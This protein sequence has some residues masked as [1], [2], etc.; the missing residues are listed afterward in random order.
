VNQLSKL[1]ELTRALGTE[2]LDPLYI[3]A[4]VSNYGLRAP[5][6]PEHVPLY[7]ALGQSDLTPEGYKEIKSKTTAQLEELVKWKMISVQPELHLSNI[8]E[9][10]LVGM[11]R[12]GSRRALPFTELLLFVFNAIL[13]SKT[14]RTVLTST[15]STLTH[16]LQ[17][18]TAQPIG[19]FVKVLIGPQVFTAI[20]Q[21]QDLNESEKLKSE[22]LDKSSNF[23]KNG[24]LTI[25]I[26][27]LPCDMVSLFPTSSGLIDLSREEKAAAVERYF[28]KLDIDPDKAL[29]KWYEDYLLEQTLL[30]KRVSNV[31]MVLGMTY[32]RRFEIIFD[33][34]TLL[35]RE[36]MS[37]G[38]GP[39]VD[40]RIENIQTFESKRLT[41]HPHSLLRERRLHS[42]QEPMY[43]MLGHPFL[44]GFE[45]IYNDV[46]ELNL[47]LKRSLPDVTMITQNSLR[48]WFIDM[49]AE[50][51]RLAE[52]L[53]LKEEMSQW[54]SPVHLYV[55]YAFD[56]PMKSW[57]RDG[58]IA[59]RYYTASSDRVE[60]RQVSDID[61]PAREDIFVKAYP[62][63]QESASAFEDTKSNLT[64]FLGPI[65]GDP[66]SGGSL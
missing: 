47:S 24:I 10:E 45:E 42:L 17:R 26:M 66:Y 57:R 39:T 40:V 19:L 2:I 61:F 8:N 50:R 32:P 27:T 38:T 35:V 3:I 7:L 30:F 21:T 37:S 53:D 58:T 59:I 51:R 28:A 56:K 25:R 34:S 44:E 60:I 22:I 43:S 23:L 31:D 62:V 15:D 16:L 18:L 54:L 48:K 11:V 55:A 1:E 13:P 29:R 20:L 14:R 52:S 12:A 49:L 6:K 5:L 33:R 65:L 63:I 36:H 64:Y 41:D 9:N 4:N 46:R